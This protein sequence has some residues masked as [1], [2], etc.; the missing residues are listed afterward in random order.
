VLI[1]LECKAGGSGK[2]LSIQYL[3]YFERIDDHFYHHFSQPGSASGMFVNI[4]PYKQAIMVAPHK[5][6]TNNM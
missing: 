1:L 5:Q 3:K 2:Y 6:L 4:A